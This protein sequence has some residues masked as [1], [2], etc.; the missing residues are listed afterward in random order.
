VAKGTPATTA[1]RRAGVACSIHEYAHGAS[2]RDY[3]VEAVELLGLDPTRVFKTLVAVTSDGGHVVAVV[4]VAASLDLKALAAALGTKHTAM[5]R[6]DD[7]ERLTGYVRGGISPVGQ[8]RALPT[9]VDA[10]AEAHP[11]IF[12]SAGRRGLELE[13]APGDLVALTGAT[14]A[15]IAR[16]AER[17]PA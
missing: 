7:A 9:V 13:L 4:P 14:V 2:S 17:G 8:K 15:E 10:S 1:A 6:P 3:G 12:V 5:A 11:T 16:L